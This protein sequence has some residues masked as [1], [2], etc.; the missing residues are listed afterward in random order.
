[1]AD[2]LLQERLQPSLLDRLTDEAP[3]VKQESRQRRVITVSKLRELMLRDLS[4][5]FNT[6]SLGELRNRDEFPCASQSVLNYG[7]PDLAGMHIRGADLDQIEDGVRQAILDFEPRILART[8]KVNVQ[9]VDGRQ[10]SRTIQFDIEGSLWCQPT[11]L[12]LY[13][14]TAVDLETGNMQISDFAC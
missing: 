11:P 13:L 7:K 10:S 2:L 12:R 4:W 3:G 5:L 8:L 6:T 9:F 14:K 1:M